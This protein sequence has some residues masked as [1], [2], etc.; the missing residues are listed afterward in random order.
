MNDESAQ[1]I[2]A[3]LM[4]IEGKLDRLLGSRGA[5][6]G[7]DEPSAGDADRRVGQTPIDHPDRRK[8]LGE[9]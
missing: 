9:I 3:L 1:T 8:L 2:V 5:G 4:R 6:D 7:P